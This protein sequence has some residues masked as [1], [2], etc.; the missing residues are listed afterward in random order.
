VIY[1]SQYQH[2][3]LK[4]QPVD[5]NARVPKHDQPEVLVDRQKFTAVMRKR[6]SARASSVHSMLSAIQL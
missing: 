4:A 2:R 6:M 1:K 5:P 3:L